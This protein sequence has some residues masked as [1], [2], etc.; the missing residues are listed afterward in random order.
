MDLYC[1]RRSFRYSVEQIQMEEFFENRFSFEFCQGN[2]L[3]H[4]TKEN[5]GPDMPFV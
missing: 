2:R 3:S 5:P 1:D 4:F